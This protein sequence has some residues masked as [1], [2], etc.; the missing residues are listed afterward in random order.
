MKKH[1]KEKFRI[2]RAY[3]RGTEGN[4]GDQGKLPAGR[5]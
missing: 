5:E 3:N 1:C 2:F 4:L